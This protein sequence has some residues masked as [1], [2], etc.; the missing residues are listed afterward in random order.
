MATPFRNLWWV[1]SVIVDVEDLDDFDDFGAGVNAVDADD[2]VA[3]D[4]FGVAVVVV[5]YVSAPLSMSRNP[6]PFWA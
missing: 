3:D 1:Q 5:E 4:D 2:V 6:S